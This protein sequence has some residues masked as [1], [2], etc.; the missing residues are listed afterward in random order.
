MIDIINEHHNNNYFSEDEYDLIIDLIKND[1]EHLFSYWDPPGIN[2]EKKANLLSTL[3]NINKT[4]L[5]GIIGYIKKAKRLLD[6]S[7]NGINSYSGFIPEQ[8]SSVDLSR[9]DESYQKME[10]NGLLHAHELAIVLVAGGLGE[11]LG[12]TGLKINIP[13]DAIQ[14]RTY[15]NIYIDHILAIQDRL[16]DETGKRTEI[17]FIIMTSDD[18]HHKTIECLQENGF[19]GLNEDQVIILKQDLVPSLNDNSAH[20]VLENPYEIQLKPHGHGDIH[21]LMYKNNI[22]KR[23]I[24][25]GKRYIV[26][27]QDTN[28]QVVNAILPS[29]GVSVDKK[30]DFNFIAVPRVP[31][32]AIGAIMK[33]V[34][35]KKE[36]TVNIE[37]NQL[38]VLLMDT[39]STEGD[40]PNENGLSIFPGNT[41]ILLI[42][43][44][45]YDRVLRKS[46]GI[47]PEFINPKYTDQTKSKFDKPARIETL[48]Q[49]ITKLFE[50]SDNIGT[51][52][53]DRKWCFSPNKN[54]ISAAKN[55]A[56]YN[57]PCESAA[58]AESDFYLSNRTKMT[59]GNMKFE[60]GDVEEFYGVPFLREARVILYPQF[61]LRL[62]DIKRKVSGGSCSKDSTLI[63]NGKEVY[64]K[65]LVLKGN[66]GLIINVCKNAWVE[67]KNLTV[68]NNG[69]QLIQLTQEE[70]NDPFIPE[71]L[72]IRGYK[73][74]Q[75]DPLVFDISEE[76]K[77]LIGPEGKLLQL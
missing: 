38:D 10:N 66:S 15:L 63:V 3:L 62:H 54:N 23:L 52:V 75:N 24:D 49:D 6:D 77:Y 60:K 17:P 30:L 46:I 56:I 22:I 27:I 19:Y 35:K 13:L 67:I 40:V 9:L 14:K 33:L 37:Y 68:D 7:R 65:N 59:F 74:I 43:I 73:I 20:I 41:N 48:M 2:D 32:E 70:L 47:I 69:F 39:V 50:S 57:V 45:M 28:A 51:T 21:T 16:Y 64:I 76:G 55:K 18:T 44:E 42:S 58:T 71:Y 1:Q 26:F 25:L 61:C 29:L 31:K 4:Y 34:G 5:G 36:F 72:R 12:Y 53:L 11:R 8:P